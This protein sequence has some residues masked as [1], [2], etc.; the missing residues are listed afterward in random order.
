MEGC[1]HVVNMMYRLARSR[2][3]TTQLLPIAQLQGG[4]V[5][6]S[7]TARKMQIKLL[8]HN[9]LI[10]EVFPVAAQWTTNL[11]VGYRTP[12]RDVVPVDLALQLSAP[13][14]WQCLNSQTITLFPL[15]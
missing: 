1:Q 14:V 11:R 10:M 8:L 3:G 12:G 7:H 15:G 4:Q 13:S 5:E 9:V 2:P 6:E